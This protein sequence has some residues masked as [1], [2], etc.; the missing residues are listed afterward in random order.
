MGQFLRRALNTFFIIIGIN[1]DIF[2]IYFPHAVVACVL[3]QIEF[4][5]HDVALFQFLTCLKL[6]IGDLS[7]GSSFLFT[8]FF[9][10][11]YCFALG[12]YFKS[13]FFDPKTFFSCP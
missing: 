3:V 4:I 12:K 10:E 7:E 5:D 6:N 11:H 2:Q 9:I 1:L 8:S 13:L